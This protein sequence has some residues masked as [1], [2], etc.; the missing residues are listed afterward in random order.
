LR[1]VPP[2]VLLF[3]DESHGGLAAL[4]GL[5]AGGYAPYAGVSRGDEPAARS[6]AAAG[7]VRLPD[8][9]ADPDRYVEEAAAAAK[10]LGIVAVLP[11]MES[12][13]RA[14]TGREGAF[15]EEI[16]V[17]TSSVEQLERATDKARL[18]ELARRAGLQAPRTV[19]VGAGAVPF[20][21]ILK[22]LRSVEVQP[23]GSLRMEQVIRVDDDAAL[24]AAVAT[25]PNVAWAVQPYVEGMLAAVSGVAW[26]GR[27]LSACHQ[28]STRIWPPGK[29]ISSFATTVAPDVPRQTGVAGMLRELGWSGIYNVQFILA[30][31][32]AYVI[33]LNPR[34][35]GSIG[36]AI[37]AGH[38]LPMWW[39]DLLLGREPLIRPYRMGVAYRNDVDDLRALV[40]ELRGG[41]RRAALRGLLPRRGTVHTLFSLRDPAPARAI[42][43][44]LR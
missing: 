42:L 34:V 31:D 10:R 14:L 33:D 16:A 40:R 26:K 9:F 4:R 6:R 2:R 37:G 29:G 21:A 41:E 35:Y 18:E 3:V 24:A 22:P 27:M 15:A 12:S 11:G 39:S 32:G 44:R 5:R 17:G 43:G 7:V 23:D 8:P 36:L 19:E 1:R 25:G 38:N 20:P 30:A 28:V 13:L